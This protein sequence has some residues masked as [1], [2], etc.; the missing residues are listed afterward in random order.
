MQ[1]KGT[2]TASKQTPAPKFE[3]SIGQSETSDSYPS[4]DHAS[5]LTYDIAQSALLRYFLIIEVD[6]LVA[7]VIIRDQNLI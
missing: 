5:D 6:L 7:I 4:C 1:G 3:A 2:K